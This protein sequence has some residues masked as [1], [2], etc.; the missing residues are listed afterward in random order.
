M[1]L[2]FYYCRECSSF[3]LKAINGFKTQELYLKKMIEYE[4]EFEMF[5]TN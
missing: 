1:L 2:L 3:C 5:A 4:Y